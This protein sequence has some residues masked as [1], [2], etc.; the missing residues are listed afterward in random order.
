[1]M[2]HEPIWDPVL[3][4]P[5]RE[6]G[7]GPLEQPTLPFGESA[8]AESMDEPSGPEMDPREVWRALS[9]AMRTEVRRD[10]LR[11]MREVIGNAPE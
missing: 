2:T 3:R 4:N 1:M 11:T 8:A 7:P 9:V 5:V 6:T 10:C